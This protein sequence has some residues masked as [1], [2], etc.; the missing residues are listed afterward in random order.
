MRRTNPDA[1]RPFRAPFYPAVPILGI[2]SCLMLMFSL[3]VA[4]WYRLIAWMALGLVIYFSYGYKRSALAAQTSA[5]LS[6]EGAV[7]PDRRGKSRE[8]DRALRAQ[9][10]GFAIAMLA[11]VVLG[12][13]LGYHWIEGWS[14]GRALYRT[15]LAITTVESPAASTLAGQVFTVVLLVAGVS[16]ALY[17]FTLIATVVVEGGLPKRFDQRRRA[18]ML[19]SLH[20][21]FVLCGYGRIGRIVAQQLLRQAVPFVVVDRDP[22][23]SIRRQPTAR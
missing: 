2:A 22:R 21:H 19:D 6:P 1:K 3:P 20:D 23:A 11:L 8:G 7:A 10:P 16:G 18:H 4:N 5:R 15:V 13:A 9:G 12:G 14:F 17:T